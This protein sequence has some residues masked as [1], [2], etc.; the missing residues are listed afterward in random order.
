MLAPHRQGVVVSV[1][2]IAYLFSIATAAIGI[3]YVHKLSRVPADDMCTGT[4]EQPA[5]SARPPTHTDSYYLDNDFFIAYNAAV[6]SQ[7]R[8]SSSTT[9]EHDRCHAN[10]YA[11]R[12][13]F[14]ATLIV[15]ALYIVFC[16]IGSI[17]ATRTMCV[18]THARDGEA[19]GITSDRAI[20]SATA[21]TCC[22]PFCR[23]YASVA[24]AVAL[25]LFFGVPLFDLFYSM[26]PRNYIKGDALVAS[27]CITASIIIDVL[28]DCL[29][30]VQ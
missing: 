26:H 4:V 15:L 7:R 18:H 25:I 8:P 9:T 6:S 22:T 10:A 3:Y 12:L 16:F 2:T 27:V 23:K 24:F 29:Y 14:G 20:V 1:L 5:P 13:C 17:I 19:E 11:L 30:S 21:R 28:V